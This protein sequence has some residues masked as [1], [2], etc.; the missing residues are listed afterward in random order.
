MGG[1]R[2]GRVSAVRPFSILG[3]SIWP[4]TLAAISSP[5]PIPDH[6]RRRAG[7]VERDG[8]EMRLGP[9]RPIPLHTRE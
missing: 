2:E 9:S 6:L 8:L 3:G 4:E 5:P 1:G 7:A